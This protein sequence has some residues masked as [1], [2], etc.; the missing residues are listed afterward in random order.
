M[1][2]PLFQIFWSNYWNKRS[3][4]IKNLCTRSSRLNILKSWFWYHWQMQH[5]PI[6]LKMSERACRRHYDRIRVLMNRW[7]KL[8]ERSN[9]LRFMHMTLRIRPVSFSLYH[10]KHFFLLVEIRKVFN[11]EGSDFT[12]IIRFIKK[13][14]L[15]NLYIVLSIQVINI[16]KS[17]SKYWSVTQLPLIN[18][19]AG[20][21]GIGDLLMKSMLRTFPPAAL[22]AIV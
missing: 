2:L 5:Q 10:Y 16:L 3:I 20:S 14:T 22:R 1:S 17:Y 19:H 8:N 15:N 6:K 7:D 4:F 11:F 21:S 9:P 13:Q 18:Q 12:F